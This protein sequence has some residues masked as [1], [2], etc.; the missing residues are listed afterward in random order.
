MAQTVDSNSSAARR[1]RGAQKAP[2]K[3]A[4][5]LRIQPEILAAFQASGPG[6]QQRINAALADW[7]RTHAPAE[8]TVTRAGTPA[9]VSA[10]TD[11][12][13]EKRQVVNA[14]GVGEHREDRRC[15]G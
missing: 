7:L 10:Q 2:R 1:V 6:W 3:V 12:N 15:R 9:V 5:S 14:D 13:R 11:R 4:L 8:L